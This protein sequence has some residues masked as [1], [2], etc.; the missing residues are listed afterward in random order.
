MFTQQ[1]NLA[2]VINSTMGDPAIAGTK[3]ETAVLNQANLSAYFAST[4]TPQVQTPLAATGVSGSPFSFQILPVAGSDFFVSSTIFSASATGGLTLSV[5]QSISAPIADV[6]TTLPIVAVP[7]TY[8][9]TLNAANGPLVGTTTFNLT[10]NPLPPPVITAPNPSLT[11][12]IGVP[13]SYQFVVTPQNGTTTF[14][15][16]GL[17]AGLTLTAAGLIGGTPTDIVATTYS[18]KISAYDSSTLGTGVLGPFNFP[19]TLPVVPVITPIPPTTTGTIGS[20]ISYQLTVALANSTTSFSAPSLPAGVT[21]TS[22]GL[23]GGTLPN[24]PGTYTATITPNNVAG[25]GSPVTLTFIANPPAPVFTAPAAGTTV[26]ATL[27][28]A[29]SLLPSLLPSAYAPTSYTVTPLPAGLTLN[30]ATGAITGV[31]NGLLGTTSVTLTAN[32]GVTG[33][34]TFNIQVANPP[35]PTITP[36]NPAIT[37]VIGTAINANLFTVLPANN[38]T[39]SFSATG[40]PTGMSIASLTGVIGGS[41]PNTV[42]TSIATITVT[43]AGGSSSVPLNITINPLPPVINP[44]LPASLTATVGVPFSY[45]F[46]A[47]NTPTGF[48]A[49]LFP[50][51]LT[52]DPVLGTVAG[53]PI[54]VGPATGTMTANN[55]GGASPQFPFTITVNPPL[56]VISPPLAPLAAMVGIPFSYTFTATNT[57]TGFSA[58]LF[59]A[60]L[61]L[62]PV[63]GKVSGT[64]IAVGLATGTITASNAGGSGSLPFAITV[65]LQTQ[66]IVITSAPALVVG[67]TGLITATGGG[68]GLPVTFTSLTPL[69]C[70]VTTVG[71]ISVVPGAINGNL[72]NIAADQAG[73]ATFAAALQVVTGITIGVGNQVITPAASP[74][75]VVVN[76]LTT[77]TVSAT[78]PSGVVTYSVAPINPAICSVNATTGAVVGLAAGTCL[79]AIDSPANANYNAALQ[80]TVSV[81]VGKGGQLISPGVSPAAVVVN[82]LASSGT[83]SAT[84]PSGVVTY[85]VAPII[86]AICSVNATTGAVIGLAAGTCVV[87]IDSPATANYNAALQV[88]V[89]VVV[90]KGGQLISPGVAPAAVAVNPLATSGTV[91]ATASSGLA[92]A[93]SVPATTTICSVN[94]NNGAITGL[95]AGSCTV[96]MNQAG[97]ANFSVAPQVTQTFFVGKGGQTIAGGTLPVIGLGGLGTVVGTANS[98]LAVTYS[99]PTTTAICSVNAVTGVVTGV[100]L[101]VCTV[102]MDQAGN[103]NFNPAPQLTQTFSV[104]KGNQTISAGA[105]P[106]AVMVNPLVSSGTVSATATSGLAVTYSVPITTAICSVNAATGAVKGL[107][108]GSCSV[109]MDQAGNVSFNAAPQVTQTFLVGKGTQTINT[110]VAPTTVVYNPLTST[111]T[112]LATTSSGLAVTYSVPATTKIC[113]VNATN[114]AVTGLAAGSCT[115]TMTQAGDANYNAAPQAVLTFPVGKAA[116]AITSGAVPVILRGGTGTVSGTASSGLIVT[117]TVPTTTTICSVNATSGLVTGISGGAC[118]V[119][120]NQVGDANFNPATQVTQTF[121]I[122]AVAQTI[123]FAAAPTTVVVNPLTSTGKVSA[124]SSS[125]LAVIYSVPTTVAICSVNANDGSVTGLNA[126]VCTVAANQAGNASFT[127]AMQVTQNITVANIPVSVRPA[128][129]TTPLNTPVTVDLANY[130]S[131]TGVSAV[132]VTAPALHGTTVVSGTRVT[133]TPVRDYFGADVFSFVAMGASGTSTSAV[134]TVSITGRPNPLLNPSVMGVTRS[135][136]AATI[137]FAHAQMS[138]FQ[139]RLES[140]HHRSGGAMSS[141][142]GSPNNLVGNASPAGGDAS[143]PNGISFNSWQ[144]ASVVAYKND[145]K[146][147]LSST[148]LLEDAPN[149]SKGPTEVLLANLVRGVLT[150]DSLNLG[151]VSNAIAPV[152]QDADNNMEVWVAGNMRLGTRSQAGVNTSFGTKGVTVGMD[153]KLD[154]TLT[155]GMGV[156]YAQDKSDIGVD[157]STSKASGNSLAGYVS[158]QMDMG[159]FVDAMIGFGKV[160]IES[161]RHVAS[162][163]DFARATRKGEQVFASVTFGYD[164]SSNELMW[165][166]YG[167]FDAMSSLIYSGTE[168][169]AG[170]NA[171]TYGNQRLSESQFVLGMRAQ[172]EAKTSFGLLQPRVRVEYQMGRSAVDQSMIAYADLLGT[173]YT[174]AATTMNSNSFVVGAGCDLSVSKVLKYTVD[175]Q[176]MNSAGREKYQSLS[177]KAAKSL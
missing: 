39:T 6:T 144:P 5:T 84:S 67:G 82:P 18:T 134:V 95:A 74:L 32:N 141:S 49:A 66:A 3:S 23:I 9:I 129:I 153:M 62:D 105:V 104:G 59:P 109:A 64:P 20:A 41:L 147:L 2:A 78:S 33:S 167:R 54:A 60:W 107:V 28:G 128:S 29:F 79:V 35:V 86:P 148:R 146:I 1:V 97:D 132:G 124:S 130:A 25:N 117:Y 8:T 38:S 47:T 10:V 13:L 96:A 101:G 93:Y 151:A 68:S 50:A 56:P 90:G 17:P 46:T 163:N 142:T 73:N 168:I 102:A 150:S 164:Y 89:N 37:G 110:G 44:P 108:P 127:A 165:S 125:G 87:A 65:A 138:N 123:T 119:A 143:A 135:A 159:P 131:G 40:L 169:G 118:S 69:V 113:S 14:T 92:V 4:Q 63:L 61:T 157:G 81:V 34:V 162:I 88:T 122:G 160:D 140:R 133:Y 137:Q 121:T 24:I 22:Q 136:T 11:G 36:N 158:L 70:T 26:N 42:G 166:P 120:M 7:T 111:G 171:L 43:N 83:V 51:W 126:G 170:A 99:V 21:L 116:Q 161:N 58:A 71:Q 75:G 177:V 152:G 173:Q 100:S 91:S 112:V 174:M 106:V 115:V 55:A 176:R 52:L 27:G 30:S 149:G 57:P 80:V 53:T 77:G 103:A 72:C 16:T 98:G 45:T 139:Q 114:G 85:S 76:P 172:S 19:I 156:G 15:A 175:Y 12:T 48:S 94:A 145:P 154:P 155:V 31:P